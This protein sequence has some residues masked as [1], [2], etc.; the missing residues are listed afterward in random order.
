MEPLRKETKFEEK[1]KDEKAFKNEQPKPDDISESAE[2]ERERSAEL[3]RGLPDAAYPEA[4]KAERPTMP[5]G[6]MPAA[7]HPSTPNAG[8]PAAPVLPKGEA[9]EPKTGGLRLVSKETKGL[10][11]A[12]EARFFAESEVQELRARW[13]KIQGEFVDQPRQAVEE[14]DNL[15]GETIKKLTEQFAEERSDVI[16]QWNSGDSVSTEIL[17]QSLRRYRTFFERLLAA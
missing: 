6:P 10:G 2:Y 15:I 13:D 3:E 11:E 7:L 17:R 9:Q 14:A 1:F 16:R 12:K 4:K 5:M 8:V